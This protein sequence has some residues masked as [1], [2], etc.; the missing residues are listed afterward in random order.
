[1]RSAIGMKASYE[2]RREGL[3]IRPEIRAAWQHEFGDIHQAIE[4]TLASGGPAF[5]VQG[6]EIGRESLL[7]GLGVAVLWNERTAT[8]LYYDGEL[9]RSNYTSNNVSAGVRM[10]F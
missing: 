2:F 7:L 9:L 3:V 5:T 6:A 10:S 1:M 8:Y 4:S